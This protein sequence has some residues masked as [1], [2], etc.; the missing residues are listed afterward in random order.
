MSKFEDFQKQPPAEH[1]EAGDNL[2]KH[3]QDMQRTST[4]SIVS[5]P[6][7]LM[8]QAKMD[9]LS[10]KVTVGSVTE[11]VD[12]LGRNDPTGEYREMARN[13]YDQMLNKSASA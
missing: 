11:K 8:S 7:D 13:V 1:H 4:D 10:S 6:S 9:E 5:K 2:S 3:V 12:R